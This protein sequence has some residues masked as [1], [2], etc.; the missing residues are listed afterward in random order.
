M[1]TQKSKIPKFPKCLNIFMGYI[2]DV[3]K[4]QK[5]CIIISLSQFVG[6]ERRK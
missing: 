1:S 6:S 3:E 4:N 2:K 5:I